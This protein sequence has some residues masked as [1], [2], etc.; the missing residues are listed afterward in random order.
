M[1]EKEYNIEQTR[2]SLA[3]AL[4]MIQKRLR[5]W[6]KIDVVV[7]PLWP[8][9]ANKPNKPNKPKE[10]DVRTYGFKVYDKRGMETVNT[11]NYDSY[12]SAFA[13]GLK[14]GLAIINESEGR[15]GRQVELDAITTM[16]RMISALELLE[17]T[18]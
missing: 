11:E 18:I 12:E 4:H 3:C 16:R 5:E 7:V 6:K 10:D 15:K 13:A 17:G 9:K 2:Y 1:T 8:D 14:S